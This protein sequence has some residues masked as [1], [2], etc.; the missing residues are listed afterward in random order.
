V[1]RLW[2]PWRLA[3]VTAATTAPDCI[4]CDAIGG[5]AQHEL[6]VHRGR[7]AFVILNLYPYNNGHLMIVPARHVPTLGAAERDEL[8]ELMELTRLAEMALTEAYSPQGINIGINLGRAAGAGVADHLHIH[9]VPRW[10]GDTNFMTVFGDA[11][12]LP[13][14]LDDTLARLRPIF[15]RLSHD[16]SS[17]TI[18]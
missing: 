6:I 13:E 11:R 8:A 14:T 5:R 9:L 12:V 2:T 7:L 16:A 10:T 18:E 3:Y 17:Q 1:Q 4:L 15:D